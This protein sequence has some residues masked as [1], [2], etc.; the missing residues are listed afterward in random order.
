LKQDYQN[1]YN[2]CTVYFECFPAYTITYPYS[3]IA[4]EVHPEYSSII[5]EHIYDRLIDTTVR[6][7][8]EKE[9]RCLN[10]LR[11][12]AHQLI[13]IH[14]NSNDGNDLFH[15][16]SLS[17]WGF[18]DDYFIL[19]SA[20]QQ[21]MSNACSSP[22]KNTIHD[23]C[24]YSMACIMKSV[25]FTLRDNEWSIEWKRIVDQAKPEVYFCPRVHQQRSLEEYHKVFV[26][27]NILRRPIIVYGPS[28]ARSFKPGGTAVIISMQ[29]VYLPLLWASHLCHKAPLCLGFCEGYFTALVPVAA[30]SDHNQF[31]VPLEDCHGNSLSVHFLLPAEVYNASNFLKHYLDFSTIFCS[32]LGKNLNVAHLVAT[33]APHERKL[34]SKYITRCLD[35]FRQRG[36]L[37]VQRRLCNNL[38]CS[39]FADFYYEDHCMQC[40]HDLQITKP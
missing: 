11:E 21:A 12:H 14:T 6:D 3:A 4:S 28:K 30:Y 13:P 33:K 10:W 35:E 22:D 5:N 34:I 29:G 39:K 37:A 26:L 15:A 31:F 8:L 1:F 17:M 38:R 27:A 23:R 19:R 7:S 9:F 24:C 20:F 25:G 18:E 16:A 36:Y 32:S 2:G 40:F